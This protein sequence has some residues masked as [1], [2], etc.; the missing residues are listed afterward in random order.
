MPDLCDRFS[1][2]LLKLQRAKTDMVIKEYG[3][4]AN[5]V[6]IRWT[7]HVDALVDVNGRIWDLEAQIRSGREGELG[8]EE[9]G[10]RALMI[11]DLNA[12]RISIKNEIAELSGE[13][14]PEVKKDHASEIKE[15]K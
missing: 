1:I 4:L 7:R 10:K 14:F 5:A 12:E 11:R 6:P 2:I 13:G 15:P 8:L 3:F 9:V